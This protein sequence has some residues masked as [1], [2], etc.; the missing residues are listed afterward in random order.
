MT[1]SETILLGALAGG[2]IFLSLP[3]GRVSQLSSRARVALAMFPVG[4]LAFLLVDV[5]EHA[6]GIVEE[7]VEGYKGGS[8][9]LGH[10]IGLMALLAAGFTAGTAGLALLERRA[11]HEHV[12]PPLAG[13]AVDA[14]RAEDMMRIG[15]AA[16]DARRRAL[17]TSMAIAAAIGVHNFAEG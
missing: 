8:S 2:T 6:M 3:F 12:P 10:A 7:A 5:G 9:S 4:I 11:G 15:T 16:D 1:F 13:G 17:R 14:L